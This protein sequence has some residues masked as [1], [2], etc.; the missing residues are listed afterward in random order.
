M[1]APPPARHRAPAAYQRGLQEERSMTLRLIARFA[2]LAAVLVLAA[3]R[4]RADS[5]ARLFGVDVAIDGR[6][7]R[8]EDGTNPFYPVFTGAL[9]RG[10]TFIVSGKIYRGGTLASGGDFG[11]ASNP[12]GPE[13]P[14]AIGTWICRGAF[15]LD[16]DQIA[17]G[18]VPHV[19]STQFFHFEDGSSI[20]SDGPE[21]GAEVLRAIVGG[22]GLFRQV[23]GDVR[24]T[25]LGV[26]TTNM[27]NVRFAFNL[28]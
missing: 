2:V 28:R 16:I 3:D 6:T 1:D 18:E 26:N 24:E 15:N 5:L 11:G 25:P 12:A 10:K 19:T 8:M 27:F 14:G 17:A 13:T 23:Q 9:A 22:T 7:W 21:G 20:V 4:P